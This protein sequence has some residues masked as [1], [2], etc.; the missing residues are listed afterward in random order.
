LRLG[1]L[2][3]DIVA[4]SGALLVVAEVRTR[5]PGALVAAFESV[6]ATKRARLARAVTRLWREQWVSIDG[7]R[8]VRIDVAAVKFEGQRTL[9]EYAP[10][11]IGG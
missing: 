8:R 5:G 6:T 1:P 7:V 2:E 10:G 9:I 11:V 3:L 4:R